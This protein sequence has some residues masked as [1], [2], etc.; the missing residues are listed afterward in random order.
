VA[1]FSLTF[2]RFL[3]LGNFAAVEPGRVYRSG[4]FHRGVEEVLHDY[5]MG[6]IL[7]LRGGTARDSWYAAEVAAARHL[8]TDYYDLPMSATRRPSRAEL[9][10]LLDLF[11]H[12]RYP[13]WIHCKS[14]SDRTGL[15]TALYRLV[16]REEPPERA[17]DAF[18]YWR[19]HIPLFG[20][21]RLH[22]PI[23]EYAAWLR[24]SHLPHTPQRFRDWVEHDYRSDGP[25]RPT[26][27]L[28]PGP[29]AEVARSDSGT[30]SR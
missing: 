19:G 30:R 7:N 18:S 14:G 9:L 21:A 4:Q 8:G 12:C 24:A 6:S 1:T 3:F 5:R 13:L 17:H 10:M 27:P 26:R 15:A 25:D 28:T 22:E 2:H 11:E 16:V 29:R 20:P 23:H